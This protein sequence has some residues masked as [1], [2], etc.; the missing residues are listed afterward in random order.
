MSPGAQVRRGGVPPLHPSVHLGILAA[1]ALIVVA[2]MV[3][4][5]SSEAVHLLGFELPPLCMWKNLTGQDCLGCGLTRSFCYMGHG[6]IAA[7]FDLHRLGPA[8][9][10]FVAM[11]LPWRLG[12]LGAWVLARRG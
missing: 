1:C 12:R 3:L 7:A 6:Q 8:F 9:F 2:S 4:T 5:P 11:Q 10:A